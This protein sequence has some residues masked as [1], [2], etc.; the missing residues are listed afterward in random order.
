MQYVMAALGSKNEVFA[1][2]QKTMADVYRKQAKYKEA[3]DLYRAC[4]HT[5]R[6]LYGLVS[7]FNLQLSSL[8]WSSLSLSLSH[9]HT[10]TGL[11]FWLLTLD[12]V[13]PEVAEVYHC[14]G[15]IAKKEGKYEHALK[16]LK[17]SIKIMEDIHGRKCGTH[18]LKTHTH[19]QHSH[20]SG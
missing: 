18:P 1:R 4:L 17:R 20:T 16:S 15:L 19:T 7:A 14:L 11:T 2:Y 9:T 5:L 6:S 13:H 10:H 8:V 3:V 12:K